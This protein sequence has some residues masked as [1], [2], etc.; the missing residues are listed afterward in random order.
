[1]GYIEVKT[2][3]RTFYPN[4]QGDIQL[5]PFKGGRMSLRL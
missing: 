2:Y 3:L 1:M 5:R 4:F